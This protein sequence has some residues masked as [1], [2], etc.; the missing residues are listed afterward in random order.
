MYLDQARDALSKAGF[1]GSSEIHGCTPEEVRALEESIGHTLPLAYKEYLLW[2]GHGAGRF[3]AGSSVFYEDLPDRRESAED[4]LNENSVSLGLP[5][6]AFVFYGHQGYQFM[7]FR[8][9]EGDNPPVYY[10]GEGEGMEA[11]A[12]LYPRFSDFVLTEIEGHARLI[13]ERAERLG[14]DSPS[15]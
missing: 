15:L 14:G 12:L 13:R 10:Y 3:L 7:Y 2:M 11:I 5:S 4:L 1:V 9:S 6:D 8:L